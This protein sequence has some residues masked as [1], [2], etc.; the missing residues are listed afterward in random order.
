LPNQVFQAVNLESTPDMVSKFGAKPT[1]MAPAAAAA[2][3]A[4]VIFIERVGKVNCK[5]SPPPTLHAD[6]DDAFF[7]K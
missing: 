3:R 1:S 2:I 7:R 6:L 5:A 4:Q